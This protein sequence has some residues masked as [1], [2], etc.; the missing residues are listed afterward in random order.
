MGK[1]TVD[2]VGDSKD[3]LRRLYRLGDKA[4]IKKIEKLFVELSEHPYTGTG[5]P[6]LL[7]HRAK[8]WSRR[9]DGKNRM[10]YTVDNDI[11]SVYVISLL[12]HYDDK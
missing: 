7:K 1:Y 10:L 5:K 2:L 6:K 9:I 11:V 3:D 12:G 8:T 4:I